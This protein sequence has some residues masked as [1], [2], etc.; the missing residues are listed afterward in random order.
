MAHVP[1][2]DLSSLDAAFE[3]SDQVVDPKFRGLYEVL[4]A[5]MR[6]EARHLPMNTVQQLLIERIA[7]NYIYMRLRERGDLGGFPS[8]A[9]QKDFNYFWLSMTQEF[10]RM[11]GKTDGGG[12]T[13]R[14]SLLKE[15]QEIIVKT[16][17]TLNDPKVRAEMLGK[18]AGAFEA[19][20][21]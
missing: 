21:I 8:S 12:G 6:Q 15:M 5:R 16:V 18:F 20:G 10:N 3:L 13:D 2:D 14:K 17:N 11:L 1:G 9:A 19:A 7:S 4:V